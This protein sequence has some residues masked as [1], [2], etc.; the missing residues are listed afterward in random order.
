MRDAAPGVG[1]GRGRRDRRACLHLWL[2]VGGRG[3]CGDARGRRWRSGRRSERGGAWARGCGRRRARAGPRLRR[4][5]ER[6]HA[7]TRVP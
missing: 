5:E 3:R 2:R 6:R 7:P 4:R 1:R